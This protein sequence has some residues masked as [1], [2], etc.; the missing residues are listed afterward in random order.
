LCWDRI[1]DHA[2]IPCG[3]LCLCS[4]CGSNKNIWRLQWKC[5]VCTRSFERGI[6]IYRS[7]IQD[8]TNRASS[9]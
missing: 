7:G 3:H 9:T 1:A 8:P 4:E 6:R 5:P 2:L